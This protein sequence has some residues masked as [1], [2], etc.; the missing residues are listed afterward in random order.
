MDDVTSEGVDAPDTGGV[1]GENGRRDFLKK[2]SIGAAA[3]WSAPILLSTQAAQAQGTVPGIS[4]VAASASSATG[5]GTINMT[6]A[7]PAGV[8]ANDRLL[9]IITTNPNTVD[10][11]TAAGWTQLNTQNA[12][13]V[14]GNN[15]RTFLLT[16]VATGGG[17]TFTF[18]R[19]QSGLVLDAGV[20]RGVIVAYRN[21]ASLGVT[22]AT[23]DTSAVSSHTLP[24]ITT[25]GPN[26]QWIVRLGGLGSVTRDWN[27]P[28][29]GHVSRADSGNTDRAI[30][31]FDIPQ[32]SPGLAASVALGNTGGTTRAGLHSIALRPS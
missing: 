18:T 11:L 15:V 1:R 24:A 28:P 8:L 27:A 22:G 32:A 4:F 23:A 6:I 31:V 2:V 12:P 30:T 16:R 21:V 14:L 9:A 29:A 20:F 19:S 26:N 25:T 13:N 17:G 7:N 10:P 5:N 3:A